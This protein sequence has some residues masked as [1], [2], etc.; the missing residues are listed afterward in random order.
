MVFRHLLKPYDAVKFV[1]VD[2]YLLKLHLTLLIFPTF[3]K[4][5]L[6]KIKELFIDFKAYT[7]PSKS[8]THYP[9][10]TCSKERIENN[11][12]SCVSFIFSPFGISS[13]IRQDHIDLS[14]FPTRSMF[15]FQANRTAKSLDQLQILKVARDFLS[16]YPD[17]RVLQ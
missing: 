12:I 9:C 5:D 2:Q 15:P 4:S 3:F 6:S 7:I 13:L 8:I 17:Y 14:D 10:R 16:K 11:S 1:V